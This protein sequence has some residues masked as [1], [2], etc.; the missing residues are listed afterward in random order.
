VKQ[1]V[2][3]KERQRGYDEA[4]FIERLVILNTGGG[5]CASCSFIRRARDP[6]RGE[7]LLATLGGSSQSP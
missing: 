1:H 4:T 6:S 7:S 2:E 3:I 5:D